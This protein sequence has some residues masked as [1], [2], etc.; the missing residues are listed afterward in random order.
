MPLAFLPLFRVTCD[1]FGGKREARAGSIAGNGTYLRDT[2]REDRGVPVRAQ[3]HGALA[4]GR[5]AAHGVV[6]LQGALTETLIG[7]PA[8]ALQGGNFT[9]GDV[10]WGRVP[11]AGRVLGRTRLDGVFAERGVGLRRGQFADPNFGPLGIIWFG[12]VGWQRVVVIGE[13][14]GDLGQLR[15]NFGREALRLLVL[16]AVS[17][18][19]CAF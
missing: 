14:R 2:A 5:P 16:G 8:R 7:V 3:H 18:H 4:H 9:R 6:L 13:S 1:K 12:F 15:R 19:P 17:D 11:C 10:G